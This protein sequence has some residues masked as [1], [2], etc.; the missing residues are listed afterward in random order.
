MTTTIRYAL[1]VYD[2]ASRGVHLWHK[3]TD[4]APASPGVFYD[5]WRL[6][7]FG[8]REAVMGKAKALRRWG[9]HVRIERR[10]YKG[11]RAVRREEVP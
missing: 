7:A 3:A 4:Y 1:Y 11:Y 6:A 2:S 8:D 9:A 5:G 10:E